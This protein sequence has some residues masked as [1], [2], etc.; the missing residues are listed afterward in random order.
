V[1]SLV[2]EWVG[3]HQ[4]ELRENLIT[5]A[6][7]GSTFGSSPWCEETAILRIEHARYLGSQRF[8]LGF[9]DGRSGTVDVRP[10]V[11]EGPGTVFAPL[12]DPELTG[13]FELRYGTLT[14]PGDL[15][16]APEY[17]YFL[18]F[19]S[20]PALQELF[21]QWGYLPHEAHV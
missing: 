13:R 7:S 5:C 2:V 19:S 11:E 18:A 20:D 9:N 4:A 6:R 12:R 1:L 17:L 14:W 21:E 8:E 16:V 15:D 10:L 3:F